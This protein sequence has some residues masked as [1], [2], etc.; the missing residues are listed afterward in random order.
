MPD[1][2]FP[3]RCPQCRL[4]EVYLATVPYDAQVK[5]DGRMYRF[6]V[7]SLHVNRCQQCGFVS[8]DT[9]TDE[10]ISQGLRHEIGLLSPAEIRDHLG[11][12]G[13]NQKQFAEHL[14]TSP[15]TVSR[16]LSGGYIQSRA[17][18]TSMRNLFELE[19]IRRST[20]PRASVQQ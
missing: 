12:L 16:W 7:A 8:F 14:K 20:G 10:E 18:D 6:H 9:Q 4:R 19:A 5:H 13:W 17:M 15:E 2:P 11:R 1:K 3:R